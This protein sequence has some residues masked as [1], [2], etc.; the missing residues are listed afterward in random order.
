MKFINYLKTIS[1]VQVYPMIS[2]MLFVLVFG[3]VLFLTFK[4]NK[5]YLEKAK[6][7]PLNNND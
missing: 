3:L 2:L 4:T 6:N 1:G 5:S 7:I